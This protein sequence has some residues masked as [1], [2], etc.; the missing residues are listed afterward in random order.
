MVLEV[1]SLCRSTP[2][3]HPARRSGPG[4]KQRLFSRCSSVHFG[5]AFLDQ[6]QLRL[7][8]LSLSFKKL[9]RPFRIRI[10]LGIR[11]TIGRSVTARACSARKPAGEIPVA[12]AT[13]TTGSTRQSP[14]A[15]AQAHSHSETCSLDWIGVS[16]Q[17]IPCTEADSSSCSFSSS[18]R[19]S[20]ISSWHGPCL[21]SVDMSVIS[22]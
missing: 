11:E 8:I 17:I 5:K 13:A 18:H 15:S 4:W 9:L 12:P 16:R 21:L 22:G 7:K 14:A 20:S 1:C 19:S 3:L 6:F 2:Y 10:L